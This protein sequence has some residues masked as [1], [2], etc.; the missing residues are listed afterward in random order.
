MRTQTQ[1]FLQ[2]ETDKINNSD[3]EKNYCSQYSNLINDL[4]C[5]L[6]DYDIKTPSTLS[7]SESN[8]DSSDSTNISIKN[9][10]Y[11]LATPEIPSIYSNSARTDSISSIGKTNDYYP[12]EKFL[13]P[14]DCMY[15]RKESS[16]E[17]YNYTRNLFNPQ[18]VLKSRKTNTDN[19]SRFNDYNQRFNKNES[20]GSNGSSDYRSN[21]R[22]H[23]EKLDTQRRTNIA[24]NGEA[25]LS[26]FQELMSEQQQ[27]SKRMTSIYHTPSNTLANT[28]R[29]DL[30]ND[31]K[32]DE[33]M[34]IKQELNNFTLSHKQNYSTNNLTNN[35]FSGQ[36][37]AQTNNLG[38]SGFNSTNF[39]SNNF[40]Y[41]TGISQERKQKIVESQQIP[42]TTPQITTSL[43]NIRPD[44]MHLPDPKTLPPGYGILLDPVY[45]YLL[46]PIN[47]SH[48]H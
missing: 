38:S 32:S 44:M 16:D 23:E 12:Y 9:N 47:H 41:D 2:R 22:F 8:S 14:L 34:K 19:I 18:A 4:D 24:I 31:S 29:K 5:E 13:D 6:N 37:N 28:Q 33:M 46:V 25:H 7:D 40:Q 30:P 45:K 21:A 27:S 1:S 39:T 36:A 26:P 43:T 3:Q 15:S 35:S 17:G 20:S 42:L 48:S 10:N 11:H